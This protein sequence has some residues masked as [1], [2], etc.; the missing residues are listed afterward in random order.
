MGQNHPENQTLQGVNVFLLME[1]IPDD[2][3]QNTEVESVRME[4]SRG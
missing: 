2:H 4:P 3:L 1:A